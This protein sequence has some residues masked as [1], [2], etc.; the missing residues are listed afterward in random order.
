MTTA[1]LYTKNI[2]IFVMPQDQSDL[3]PKNN[4]VNQSSTF[5]HNFHPR[6]THQNHPRLFHSHYM[7]F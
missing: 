5:L 3:K 7:D 2:Q 1:A 4:Q 6:K